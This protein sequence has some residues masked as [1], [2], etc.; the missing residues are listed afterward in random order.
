MIKIWESAEWGIGD[1]VVS[2]AKAWRLLR[3]TLG[4]DEAHRLFAEMVN[5]GKGYHTEPGYSLTIE[6]I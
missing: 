4:A 1:L 6:R 5:I 3:D 2:K